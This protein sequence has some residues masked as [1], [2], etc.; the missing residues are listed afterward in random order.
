MCSMEGVT[1]TQRFA[2]I[3]MHV[4]SRR[5]AILVGVLLALLIA[6]VV[7]SRH[8]FRLA[9]HRSL[10]EQPLS[11]L[12]G[13]DVTVNG[14]VFVRLS[15][16]PLLTLHDVHLADPDAPNGREAL[17]AR[18]MQVQI[19]ALPRLFDRWSI[20]RLNMT[21]VE[22]C[23][24]PSA[25][26]SC[27]WGRVA[28]AV[29]DITSLGRVSVRN[30]HI[31]CRGGPCG[32]ELK[33]DIARVSALAWPHEPVQVTVNLHDSDDVSLLTLVGGTWSDLRAD[34]PWPVRVTT[35]FAGAG[36]EVKG[37]IE[38]PR[39]PSGLS[40]NVDAHAESLK[41]R[42]VA[43][44]SLRVNG[45]LSQ[46]EH[47]YAFHVE[48]GR[49]GDGEFSVDLRTDETTDGTAAKLVVA[50]THLDLDPWIDIPTHG[51]AVG[52]HADLTADI[53]SRGN[54]L[55]TLTER[56]TG[57][58]RV[59]AGPIELPIDEVERWSKGLLKLALA[60]PAEGSVTHINC[61]GAPFTVSNGRAAS[62]GVIIDTE[63]VHMRAVGWIEIRNSEMD[64]IIKPE[65]KHGPIESAPLVQVTGTIT[66]PAA[67]LAP[68]EKVDKSLRGAVLA[69][70]IVPPANPD[71]PCE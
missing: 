26:S 6:S 49:L 37:E 13:F 71:R 47:G 69:E 57:S 8:E 4:S 2:R 27:N 39:T 68:A 32:G 24:S 28:S 12:L 36:I 62:D 38:R 17:V 58:M 33:Q 35:R 60:L 54:T 40:L 11:R 34:R 53:T 10:I 56:A 44:G 41:W 63:N 45:K 22:L 42:E 7:L 18:T 19:E 20:R 29:D 59:L 30:L 52:G 31:I 65:L 3:A 55:K 15:P 1:N 14:A 51:K 70:P 23:I 5:M 67:R 61:I 64:F 46:H 9:H 21:D 66:R 25:K 50:A 48:R 16:R 43:L